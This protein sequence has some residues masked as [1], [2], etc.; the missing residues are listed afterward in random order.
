MHR[1]AL[2]R[3]EHYAVDIGTVQV[4]DIGRVILL[5]HVAH[6]ECLVGVLRHQTGLDRAV[7]LRYQLLDRAYALHL[8]VVLRRPYRQR[9]TPE[10]RA[11]QVPVH[12]TLQ[13]LAEASRAGRL[14]VPCYR[15]VELYHALFERRGADEPRV[16]RIVQHR[17][18]GAPAVRIRVYVLLDL[19]DL[20]L[21]FQHD[22]YVYVERRVALG[23][24]LVV[25]VLDVTSGILGVA[26]GVD[27][28]LDELLVE[29][30]DRVEAAAAVDHGLVLAGLVDHEERS[31]ARLTCH[32]V[33]VGTEC[34][35]D[36]DYTRTVGHRNVVAA[37]DAERIACGLDPVDQLLVLHTHQLAAAPCPA[38]DGVCAL[39][40][41]GKECRH[42]RRGHYDGLLRICIGV[43]ALDAYILDV[44]SHGQ[45]RIR[46]QR[47]RGS[48]PCEEVE[49]ALGAVEQ[50]LA[51]LVAHDAELRG[52]GRILDVAVA[53]G[54]VQLV[55]RQTRAC[56]RRVGLY[57]V[58]L[59][60]Q[61]LVE[62]LLQQIPQRLDI[63][64][65]VCDVRVVHVDP[66]AH[67]AR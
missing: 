26:P 32:A 66:V 29:I 19:E 63:L 54:L 24:R 55:C 51:A 33:V 22:R 56:G 2:R 21:G 36:V 28:G 4:Y 42:E 57:G 39:H 23:Q 48:G 41:L 9:R 8:R 61:T 3:D 11:R 52:A 44:G 17:L 46:R 38:V 50:L 67:A 15:A 10:A 40:L 13:P 1:L 47:P 14:G 53:A 12:Q 25:C 49:L 30:L 37:D 43:A 62:E 20:V 5:R 34:R 65:V 16:E 59:V 58:A 45:R 6:A 35:R 31:D 64:V 18:V 27:I 60:E 7:Y